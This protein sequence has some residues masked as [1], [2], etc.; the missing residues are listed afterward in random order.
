M[1]FDLDENNLSGNSNTVSVDTKNGAIMFYFR[2]TSYFSSIAFP[3]IFQ[4]S[5]EM[6]NTPFK[7]NE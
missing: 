2:R 5:N 1:K 7:E 4:C 6:Q 3:N